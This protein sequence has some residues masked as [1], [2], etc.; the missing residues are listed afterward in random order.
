MSAPRVGVVGCDV[1]KREIDKVVGNDPM[2]VHKEYLE[3]GLHIDPP[4]LKFTILDKVNALQGKVDAVFLGY[5]ICQSLKGITKELK[6]P[7]VMLDVD[8]CI[9]AVLTPE[10]YAA[11]KRTCTGT[12][13]ATPGWAEIGI[14]GTTREFHLDSAKDMGYDAM[15]FLKLMF[16]GYSRCLFI[17]TNIGDREHW[18]ARS[19]EFAEKLELR[20]ESRGCTLDLIEKAFQQTKDLAV[21]IN[22]SAG[23]D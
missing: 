22:G 17:D 23:R 5:G 1:I 15:F 21:K 2:V 6:V 13:F 8:D 14:E 12:W 16:E 19:K 11:E 7:T 20:H 3:Y 4:N 18:E 10:G 9:A